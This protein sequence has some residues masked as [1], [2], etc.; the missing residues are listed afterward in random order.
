MYSGH[1]GL[2]GRSSIKLRFDRKTNQPA[3]SCHIA[4]SIHTLLLLR[5]LLWMVMIHNTN[6]W[7]TAHEEHD[8]LRV[9]SHSMIMRGMQFFYPFFISAYTSGSLSALVRYIRIGFY[10]NI[11]L[12]LSIYLPCCSHS[13]RSNEHLRCAGGSYQSKRYRTCVQ[14]HHQYAI[15]T[16]DHIAIFHYYDPYINKYIE[17]KCFLWIQNTQYVDSRT[18][19][20]YLYL[21]INIH[22]CCIHYNV[23]LYGRF[24][25]D[26]GRCWARACIA[27][28]P[29]VSSTYI[30]SYLMNIIKCILLFL[31]NNCHILYSY[32]AGKHIDCILILDVQKKLV[33]VHTMIHDLRDFYTP[34]QF[35]SQFNI[36]NNI[37]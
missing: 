11:N 23:V 35:P 7:Y 28:S 13:K 21:Y 17:Y 4:N 34:Q 26:F 33:E 31:W 5:L 25:K 2:C 15:V 9:D 24:G 32:I 29:I 20:W 19:V 8:R 27:L 1:F 3:G 10:A 16:N 30:E 6:N 12:F 14:R 18:N 37:A 22:L 36:S